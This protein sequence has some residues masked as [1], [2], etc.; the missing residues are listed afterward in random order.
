MKKVLIVEDDVMFLKLFSDVLSKQ[1]QVTDCRI[2]ANIKA[3]ATL[4]ENI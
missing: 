1:F 2:I 3:I 4:E